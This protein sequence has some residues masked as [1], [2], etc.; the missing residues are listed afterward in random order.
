MRLTGTLQTWND[1]RGFGFIAPAQ[2]GQPVFVHIKSFPTGTGRPVPGQLLSF[3][4][5]HGPDGRQRAVAVAFPPRDPERRSTPPSR[6]RPDRARTTAAGSPLRLLAL[7]VLALVY[8]GVVWRW[9]FDLRVPLLYAGLSLVTA[10][11][12]AVDK[13]SA[14]RGGWRV[15]ENTLHMLAL[16]GGWPGALLA[17]EALRHKT[18]KPA[19]I[20]LFWAT[21]AGNLIG[22]LVWHQ[23]GG[24]IAA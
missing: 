22:L 17:Q 8:A 23:R 21:V 11:V 5:G 12:Y 15:P 14:G 7:P 4:M 24:V 13:S 10:L 1:D 2:G 6:R 16:V 18:A 20:V 3:E 19:F 9:G